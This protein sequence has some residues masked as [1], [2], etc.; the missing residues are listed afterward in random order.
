MV[1]GYYKDYKHK[2]NKEHN[3]EYKRNVEDYIGKENKR[4]LQPSRSKS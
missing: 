2:S 3:E 4:K 1:P